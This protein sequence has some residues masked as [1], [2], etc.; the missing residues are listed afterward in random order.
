[1]AKRANRG[2]DIVQSDRSDIVQSG[3]PSAQEQCEQP[4][5]PEKRPV[6]PEEAVRVKTLKSETAGG[7]KR[8]REGETEEPP[9]A[10]HQE[11][12]IDELG[13]DVLCN[14]DSDSAFDRL[15]MS[16]S[17]CVNSVSSDGCVAQYWDDLSGKRLE[18]EQVQ[19]A[20][21]EELGELAKH[22]V[23]TKVP[24]E[25]CWHATGQEPIGTRWVDV[26]KGDDVNPVYRS[27]L[28][29]Q[30]IN[31]SKREDLFAA[32]PPLEANKLLF[33]CA[34]TEGIGF[35]KGCKQSG[36]KL[37][38]IDVRRAYFHAPARRLVFVKLP[39]DDA[40]QGM[41]GRLLK[42]LYGTRD[43]AQNWEHAYV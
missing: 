25:E 1:M 12:D 3:Q 39:A 30:E 43:A 26:N 23:Y 22:K 18:P 14:S 37:D 2:S 17:M 27:R 7:R 13:R 35:E 4:S 38:F 8:N 10:K 6:E 20:R 36:M 21:I 29:A 16:S 24:L 40:Q 33:S 9:P 5:R 11:L 34:V 31:R 28:V 41:C 15:V 19:R 32:T 42:A